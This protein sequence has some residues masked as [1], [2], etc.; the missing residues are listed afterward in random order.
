[1]SASLLSE[2]FADFCESRTHL[3]SLLSRVPPAQKSKIATLLGAFLR[4]PMTLSQKF[5]IELA[6]S[7]KNSGT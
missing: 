1:M 2:V 5:G 3:D 4:R 6:A 7:H